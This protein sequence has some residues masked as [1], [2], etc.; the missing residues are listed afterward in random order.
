MSMLG[1][2]DGDL[3]EGDGPDEQG[4]QDAGAWLAPGVPTMSRRAPGA[5]PAVRSRTAVV[6]GNGNVAA[7]LGRL[8]PR[9]D[10][11]ARRDVDL[12]PQRRSS[13]SAA[14]RPCTAG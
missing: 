5:D 2:C 14:P 13:R 6:L 8:G 7:V 3:T 9:T 11:L 12:P 4:A 1:L 10:R